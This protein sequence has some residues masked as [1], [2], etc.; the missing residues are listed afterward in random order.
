[1]HVDHHPLIKDFPEKREQLQRLRS[2]GCE[3]VQGFLF[4]RA[5]PGNELEHHRGRRKAD[6]P[7]ASVTPFRKGKI[8]EPVEQP[9]ITN[10][11]V[12]QAG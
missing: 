11:A 3:Q 1:M 2:T 12:G 4:S 5:R 10:R 8:A 9:E 7:K 6:A